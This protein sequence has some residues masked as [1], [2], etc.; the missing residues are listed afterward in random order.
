[1]SVTRVKAG[2][3]CRYCWRWTRQAIKPNC[4]RSGKPPAGCLPGGQRMPRIRLSGNAGRRLAEAAGNLSGAGGGPESCRAFFKSGS[5]P[6]RASSHQ[7]C[8]SVPR[9]IR[10]A[11]R[12]GFEV[13]DGRA[14][15]VAVDH[16]LCTMVFQLSHFFGRDIHDVFGCLILGHGHLAQLSRHLLRSSGGRASIIFCICGLRMLAELLV[17][18]IGGAWLSPASAGQSAVQVDLVGSSSRVAPAFAV[19]IA[20]QEVTVAVHQENLCATV[21]L[22]GVPRLPVP[23]AA[24]VRRRQSGRSRPEC[25][26]APHPWRGFS[27]TAPVMSGHDSS[28]CR[29]EINSVVTRPPGPRPSR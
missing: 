23:A 11:V 29:S 20:D 25:T 14:V 18:H 27:G 8:V 19:V 21:A 28:R 3:C 22:H 26:A 17:F 24:C 16:Q 12:V 1:M 5:C 15:S 13:V 2:G 4:S 9:T 6:E 7:T 10:R